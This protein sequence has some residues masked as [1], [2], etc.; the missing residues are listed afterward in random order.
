MIE[1]EG[2]REAVWRLPGGPGAL[3]PGASRAR[4]L[5]WSGRTAPARPPPSEASPE[6]SSR[7]GAG[8]GSAGHDLAP[9][10]GRGQVAAGLH[11]GR[12]ASVRVPH[13]RG[14]PA[15]RRPAVPGGRRQTTGSPACWRSWS[16]IDK[17]GA[18]PGELSRGMKQ[19]LAIACGLLHEPTGPAAGRAA[20]R[21]GPGRHPPDEGDDHP[22]RRGRG[23]RHPEL[24]PAP[25]G[26]GDLHPRAGDATGPGRGVRH[27]RRDRRQPARP[28][29]AGGWRTCFSR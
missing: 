22:A 9:R 6:S 2:L 13:G 17:R 25:P 4:C 24:A 14:A 12:A 28:W 21:P 27:D 20:H 7:A 19:K 8:S 26:R 10:S 18:L 29:A 15:I 23:R 11:P 16:S 3:L 5:G 1:V